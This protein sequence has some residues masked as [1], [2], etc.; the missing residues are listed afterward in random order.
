MKGPHHR[1]ADSP[2]LHRW[3]PSLYRPV[4]QALEADPSNLKALYRRA[5]AWLATADFVEA[6]LDIRRGL[7]GVRP[8]DAGC[9][10]V[11]FLLAN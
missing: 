11:V 1:V 5:Q 2:G 3:C 7:A 4:P 10:L 8:L 9:L 6:E